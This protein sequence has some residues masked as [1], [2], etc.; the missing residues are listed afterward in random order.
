MTRNLYSA[1]SL[2]LVALQLMKQ[3]WVSYS[4]IIWDVRWN[5]ENISTTGGYTLHVFDEDH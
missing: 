2:N 4:I 5:K 3:K 1:Y